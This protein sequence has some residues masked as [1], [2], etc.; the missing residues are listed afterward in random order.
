MAPG[1]GISGVSSSWP[2]R[3]LGFSRAPHPC[4][5]PRAGQVWYGVPAHASEALEAAMRDAVPHLFEHT[6]DLLYQL[7]TMVSPRELRVRA[8]P[9]ACPHSGFY[10][11][12]GGMC[13]TSWSRWSARAS[14]GCAHGCARDAASLRICHKSAELRSWLGCPGQGIGYG[15]VGPDHT[16][17]PSSYPFAGQAPAVRCIEACWPRGYG[18]KHFCHI[19]HELAAPHLIAKTACR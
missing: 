1:T 8:R 14:C 12:S 6:P 17:G 3:D 19:P 15:V 2:H 11:T 13:C 7:V 16:L 10:S 4:F 5:A 9:R 18:C